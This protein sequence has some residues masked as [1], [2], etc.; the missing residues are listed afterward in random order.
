MNSETILL[1]IVLILLAARIAGEMAAYLNIPSVIG[2]LVAGIVIGPSV[3][4]L[5]EMSAPLQL[6]AEIGIILLLFE[7][8][9]E[10]DVVKLTKAGSKALQVAFVGVVLPF[11][12]GYVVSAYL[13]QLSFMI[14]LFIASTLVA[15]SIGIT[16]RVLKD[17]KKQSSHEAQIVIGAAVIDDII[18]IIFL[19]LLYEFSQH[20]QI[21]IWNTMKVFFFILLFFLLAPIAAKLLAKVIKLWEKKSA[22]PGLL[23]TMIVSLILFFAWLAH[24]L[25]APTLLGG[26][27]AGLAISRQFFLPSGTFL[28]PE[29]I[30]RVEEQMRPIIHL[31]TPIF[32]VV[33]GLA[34]N[35]REVPVESG[36]VWLLSGALII[37]ACVGKLFSGIF[38]ANESFKTKMVIGTS[39]IPRGEVGLIFANVGL[40]TGV[41]G[42][43]YYACLILVVTVTTLL[44]P[45]LLR[46]LYTPQ[47]PTA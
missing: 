22:I 33:V 46:K 26:F 19:S 47:A 6:L 45:F 13:F 44:A 24:A 2:E 25:G 27:A 32:F 36:Y 42:N 17:L 40:T 12:L 39:M 4:G 7:V 3:F 30:G 9:L 10:T 43:E 8:G 14:S 15:T 16:L 31:F 38:L 18:G 11:G 29:F 23:P 5:I 20:G 35:L 28:S 41:L 37:A 34:L 1:Q 21:N